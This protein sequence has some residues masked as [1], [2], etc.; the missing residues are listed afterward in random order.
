MFFLLA[1]VMVSFN[2]YKS[3]HQGELAGAAR[4]PPRPQKAYFDHSGRR[5][6]FLL[7]KEAVDLA[8]RC[9]G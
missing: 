1:T 8:W 5:R 9:P 4:G 2:D 6:G 3:G 7:N